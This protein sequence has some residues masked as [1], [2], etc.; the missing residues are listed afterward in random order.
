MIDVSLKF[1]KDAFNNYLHRRIGAGFGE[2]DIGPVVDDK[3]NWAAPKNSLC[4]TV[5]Q[6]EEERATRAQ[7]PDRVMLE[8]RDISLPPPLAI[9][10]VILVSA[11]F[12]VYTEGLR[13]LAYVLAYFQAHP[14]F[15]PAEQPAMPAGL[16]RLSLELV[17]YG[18][19]QTNQMWACLGAKHLPSVVYRLRMLLI[20]DLEPLA[21]GAPVSHIDIRARGT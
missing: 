15:T 4:L 9:N 17:N 6:I 8:G 11:R 13:L 21:T 16:D 1:L 19:E 2:I 3:G 7:M 12:D 18:P 14:L 20:Q 5:F 10:L